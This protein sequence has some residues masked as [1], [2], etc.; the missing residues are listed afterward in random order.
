[1]H[2]ISRHS[3][4]AVPGNYLEIP[5]RDFFTASID[6]RKL[7]LSRGA[8]DIKAQSS[9]T[10]ASQRLPDIG[11]RNASALGEMAGNASPHFDAAR[12]SCPAGGQLTLRPGAV[13][14]IA[15]FSAAAQSLSGP[16]PPSHDIMYVRSPISHLHSPFPGLCPPPVFRRQTLVSLLGR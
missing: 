11:S 9:I 1:M 10:R 3:L 5:G 13:V 8:A 14:G 16:L 15:R 6:R 7:L 12:N 2:R 4:W